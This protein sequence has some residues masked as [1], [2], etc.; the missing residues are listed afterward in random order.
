MDKHIKEGKVLKQ[1]LRRFSFIWAAFFS[2]IALY[3]LVAS[4]PVRLWALFVSTGFIAIGLVYPMVL[5]PFFRIWIKFGNVVGAINAKIILAIIFYL[6][7]TPIGLT[8]RIMGKDSLKKKLDK[9]TTTYWE[10]RHIQPTSME[11]QF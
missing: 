5:N 3:P 8:R 1:T 6:I 10:D 11:K 4:S 9:S 7:V 2:I